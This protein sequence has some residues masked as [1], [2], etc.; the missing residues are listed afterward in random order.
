M[1][2]RCELVQSK[3][4]KYRTLYELS[5]SSHFGGTVRE[6]YHTCFM[7]SVEVKPVPEYGIDAERWLARCIALRLAVPLV[8][9]WL[10]LRRSCVD[11]LW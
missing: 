10:S 2:D 4:R 5:V 9:A 8:V 7:D 6:I 3:R 1:Y 11:R